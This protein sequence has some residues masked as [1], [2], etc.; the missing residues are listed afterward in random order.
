MQITLFPM[1]GGSQ[2]IYCVALLEALISKR[3]TIS[4]GTVRPQ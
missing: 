1:V 4:G 2:Q 3:I